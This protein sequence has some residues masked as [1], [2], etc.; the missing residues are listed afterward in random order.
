MHIEQTRKNISTEEERNLFNGKLQLYGYFDDDRENYE[1]MYS[2]KKTFA[3]NVTYDFPKIL[4]SDLPL[5]IYD[6]SYSI[7][8]SAVENF[9]VESETILEKI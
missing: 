5:G 1:K 4:K 8:I 9:I 2:L 3:F 7:E 6:I